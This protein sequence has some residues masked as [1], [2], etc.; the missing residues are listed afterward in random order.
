MH[1]EYFNGSEFRIL[2]RDVIKG[3]VFY[4]IRYENG[5]L[6]LI[7]ETELRKQAPNTL[8]KYLLSCTG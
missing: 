7:P 6:E 4:E 8:H 3:K 2:F 5:L 1:Q